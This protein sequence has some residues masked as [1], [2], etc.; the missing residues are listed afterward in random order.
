MEGM[1][2]LVYSGRFRNEI[3]EQFQIALG[4]GVAQR[5]G[6]LVQQVF[7]LLQVAE[8]RGDEGAPEHLAF[9]GHQIGGHLRLILRHQ[10]LDQKSVV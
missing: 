2:A 4:A 7:E 5:N 1:N 9:Y 6:I 3:L 8:I 10:H